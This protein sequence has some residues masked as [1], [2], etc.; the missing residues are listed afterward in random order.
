MP[1]LIDMRRRIRSVKNTQQITK[2][3]KMV[4][5]AKL[6]RAQDRVVASRPYVSLL[7]KVLANVA[8]AAPG[9][10]DGETTH[11]LLARRPETRILLVVITGDK[12][13]AGAFNANIIKGAQRFAA[14]H[15][16][17]SIQLELIG[18]KG[19]DFF[20]KR[21]AAIS[22]EYIGLAAKA[23][24]GEIAAI[25]RKAIGAVLQRRDRRR[26]R[27]LQRIQERSF[28]E[29]HGGARAAGGAAGADRARGLYFR[30]A[31]GRDAGGAAA[32]LRGNGILS[33]AAG[34]GRCR[35][36]R[37]H[38][39]DGSRDVQRRRHDREAD[40]VYEPRAPGQHH[41]GN[42][43]SG[44]RR[45]RRRVERTIWQLPHQTVVGKSSPGGRTGRGLRVSRRADSPGLYRHPHHQRRLRRARAHRHHLRG[46]AA[47]RRRPRAHHRA[48]AHRGPGAR[49]E[50]HQPGPSRGSAGRT[51]NA[52]PRA[53]RDRPAG[54]PDG[55]GQRQ[56]VL[57]RFTGRRPRSKTS[58]RGSKCSRP[59]SR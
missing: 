26:P 49:H 13:L 38:D 47:H 58:R 45:R 52:G 43:R 19:R 3:M 36:C 33:R 35:A 16:D 21:H 7:R 4:S 2:A 53:Q 31:A 57:S 24:Y 23:V 34:I 20:R 28:P 50:G 41:Q 17:A 9:V 59:A 46:A 56:E 30:P 44:E 22:G 27:G 51:R 54:G 5:A 10:G 48:A 8:A 1:S 29:A 14:E 55:S 25:A 32:A 37:A 18:R 39:G 11:P 40:A 15:A 6:R 42:H 12:G